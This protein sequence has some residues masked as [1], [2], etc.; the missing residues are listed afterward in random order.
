MEQR[1]V[2]DDKLLFLVPVT[3]THEFCIVA[4]SVDTTHQTLVVTK[5]EDGQ[6]GDEADGVEQRALVQ[7]M[8]DIVLEK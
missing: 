2:D 6:A 5:E 4:C 8:G 7:L 3:V 1:L